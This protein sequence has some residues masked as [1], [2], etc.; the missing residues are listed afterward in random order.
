MSAEQYQR[1]VNTLDKEIADLEKKKAAADKKSADEQKKAASVNISKNASAVTIKSKIS[2]IQRHED[3]SRKASEESADLQKKIAE[4]RAKR[5][6]AYLKLQ[7]EQQA[8]QKKA[9]RAQQKMISDMQRLYENRIADLEKQALPV[10]SVSSNSETELMPEYDVFVSH[11]WEDKESFA[12]EFVDELRKLGISVWYDT[13]QIRWGDSMRQRID[14]GL[15]KSRFGVVILSPNYI[16]EGKYWTKAELDGLFQLES[17]RGKAILP[18]WHDLTKKQVMEFSPIIANKKAMTTAS[19]TAQEI[20]EEL[21]NLLP[22]FK[23]VEESENGQ[24]SHG[25]P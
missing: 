7:K 21:A 9:Q 6:D 2:E 25:N 4:K 18:I 19:M 24:T 14:D 10:V 22:D 17:I 1:M 11:A 12:D 8:E 3:A 5:N 13:S 20:A 15:N 23:R 16:A